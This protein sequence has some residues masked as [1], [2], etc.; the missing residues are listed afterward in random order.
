MARRLAS[1]LENN[2][3]LPPTLGSYRS[4]KDTWTNV[5][6]LISDVHDDFKRK[7][8]T[9]VAALDLD[10]VYNIIDSEYS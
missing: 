10:D 6:A 7:E 8:E 2:N 9:L 4:G 1:Q 5:A 3:M